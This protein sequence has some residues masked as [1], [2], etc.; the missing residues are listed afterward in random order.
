M[1]ETIKR[2]YVKT[3]NPAVVA[4]AVAKGWITQEEANLILSA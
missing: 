3:Q 1:L 4:G 2:L